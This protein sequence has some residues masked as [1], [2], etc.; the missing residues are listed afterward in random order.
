MTHRGI[1]AVRRGVA[2]E[3]TAGG[4]V[5]RFNLIDATGVWVLMDYSL[6]KSAVRLHLIVW[7]ALFNHASRHTIIRQS[8]IIDRGARR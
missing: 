6:E 8:K 1:D 3:S 2:Q 5:L 7:P 4:T